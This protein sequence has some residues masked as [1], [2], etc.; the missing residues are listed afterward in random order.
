MVSTQN[1]FE[2]ATVNL[3]L[4]ATGGFGDLSFNAV[5]LPDGLSMDKNTG[6]DYWEKLPQVLPH[7]ALTQ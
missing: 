2:G 4:N 6:L 7:K 5:G 3:Q 1:S